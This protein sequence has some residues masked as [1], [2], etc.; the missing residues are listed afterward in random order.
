M[1][2]P[3]R[4]ANPSPARTLTMALQALHIHVRATVK[5]VAVVEGSARGGMW[6]VPAQPR[7]RPSPPALG[8]PPVPTGPLLGEVEA[9]S[10]VVNIT[11]PVRTANFAGPGPSGSVERPLPCRA[12]RALDG[13]RPAVPVL[14]PGGGPSGAAA[15]GRPTEAP[16]CAKRMPQPSWT[17][18]P[19]PRSALA[20]LR[21]AVWSD[22]PGRSRTCPT[23]PHHPARGPRGRVT[24]PEMR[25][26]TLS[27]G[28]TSP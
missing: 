21:I 5:R 20:P 11:A 6:K 23:P 4:P 10:R 7:P 1:V 15:P 8:D 18:L 22:Y 9:R 3:P 17:V 24:K 27:F 19:D 14:G 12:Q 28:E 13:R 16:Q 2:A 25:P 26:P